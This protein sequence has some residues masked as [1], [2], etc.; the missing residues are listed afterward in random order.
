MAP[1][2]SGPATSQE[3]SGDLGGAVAVGVVAVADLKL[4][5]P[6][7]FSTFWHSWLQLKEDPASCQVFESDECDPRALSQTIVRDPSPCP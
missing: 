2:G 1:I 6:A 5:L 4:A 7:V 3:L